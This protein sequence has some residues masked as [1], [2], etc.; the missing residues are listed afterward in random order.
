MVLEYDKMVDEGYSIQQIN[1]I[2][3]LRKYFTDDELSEINIDVDVKHIRSLNA[4]LRETGE[5][6]YA[7]LRM[8]INNLDPN[9]A[10]YLLKAEFN[11]LKAIFDKK[12]YYI[13]HGLNYRGLMNYFEKNVNAIKFMYT[14]LCNIDSADYPYLHK[15]LIPDFTAGKM[16][17]AYA[18]YKN[19][20]EAE[21]ENL[22]KLNRDFDHPKWLQSLIKHKF[23]YVSLINNLSDLS[24]EKLLIS[25]QKYKI[26]ELLKECDYTECDKKITP[27]HKMLEEKLDHDV[28]S[29]ILDNYYWDNTT[30]C[31]KIYSEL[32]RYEKA[33]YKVHDFF[34]SLPSLNQMYFFEQLVDDGYEDEDII[35]YLQNFNDML[36]DSE[37]T[38]RMS[39]GD[40]EKYIELFNEGY[41]IA[42]VIKHGWEY[43][44]INLLIKAAEMFDWD[45]QE[46]LNKDFKE[47]EFNL[48]DH[49]FNYRRPD[50]V[51]ALLHCEFPDLDSYE[52]IIAIL[53]KDKETGE[54]H[55]IINLLFDK[56]N[57]IFEDYDNAYE[58][59]A[60]QKY[61]LTLLIK[62]NK[63]DEEKLDIIRDNKIDSSHFS[64]L[65]LMISQGYE[66]GSLLK[67]IDKLTNDDLRTAC[68]YM[69]LGF[70][71]VINED[72]IEKE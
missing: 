56:G 11:E 53:K 63:I 30:T 18:L 17:L 35:F 59:D 19:G 44:E 14:F 8:V 32:I 12:Q 48:I 26:V 36:L 65:A 38:L 68:K 23:D 16:N 43:E 72:N 50:I 37:V 13:D 41:D 70:S 2:L 1:Q 9:I 10:N 67:R 20:M 60:Y 45:L 47:F 15:F 24:I 25:D 22:S 40:A 33:G 58:F 54:H 55:N 28:I 29:Y 64:L 66:V 3:S 51:E 49:C 57:D 42:N 5:K 71:L 62:D 34:E 21:I 27:C 52:N 46:L 39:I 6:D 61:E 31:G 7:A 4:M 69:K